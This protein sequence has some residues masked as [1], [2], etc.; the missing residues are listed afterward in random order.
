MRS[1]FLYLTVLLLTAVALLS[2]C[3]TLDQHQRVWI[4]QPSDRSWWRGEEAATGMSDVWVDFKSRETGEPVRLHGLWLAQT[5]FVSR[6][7]APVLLYLHGARYNVMGSAFR[8][9]RIHELER[10]APHHMDNQINSLD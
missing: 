8:A 7:N 4:F 6:A 2:G 5:D 1:W 10:L 9:R 3:T